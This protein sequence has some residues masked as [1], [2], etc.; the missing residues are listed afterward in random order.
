M[1][2][3]TRKYVIFYSV[4]YSLRPINLEKK[5]FD[6]RSSAKNGIEKLAFKVRDR[7]SKKYDPPRV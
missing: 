6:I 7:W 3:I 5:K 1:V 2:D 4:S